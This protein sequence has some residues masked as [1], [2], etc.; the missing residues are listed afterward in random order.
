[1]TSPPVAAS[2][3][4]AAIFAVAEAMVTRAGGH[5][6]SL[7]EAPAVP[8]K[9]QRCGMF[10]RTMVADDA[11]ANYLA[12]LPPWLARWSLTQ[13]WIGYAREDR[14][15]QPWLQFY[16]MDG[17]PYAA[18]PGPRPRPARSRCAAVQ[19]A[20]RHKSLMLRQLPV[21]VSPESLAELVGRLGA[22]ASAGTVAEAV[23]ADLVILAV[24][25]DQVP[26]A[27]QNLPDWKRRVVIDATNQWHGPGT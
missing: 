23:Q 21:G 2:P 9:G 8:D 16:A 24:G 19:R 25:W 27:V 1:M 18:Q 26:K 7:R 22:N 15:L 4:S 20:R 13:G 12:V 5:V 3:D 6:T 17:H 10:A 14:D 11:M